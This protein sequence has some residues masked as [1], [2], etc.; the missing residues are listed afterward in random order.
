[1]TNAN[2]HRKGFH[3]KLLRVTLHALR[4]A[5]SAAS[6]IVNMLR[7]VVCFFFLLDVHIRHA[8]EVV[9][10]QLKCEY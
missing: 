9:I 5:L 3:H 1:M 8:W 6:F 2:K 7:A 10:G 4:H